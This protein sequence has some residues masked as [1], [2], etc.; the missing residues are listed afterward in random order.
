[1]PP[2][3]KKS[4][5][6]DGMRRDLAALYD[7]DDRHYHSMSHVEDL[8]RL[9]ERHADLIDNAAE[10]EAAIWF[11]DAILDTHRNDNEARSADLARDWLA[12][13]AGED[14]IGRIALMI[15]ATASHMLP[16]DV[17][18]DLRARIALFLDMDLSILGAEPERFDAYEAAVRKEYDWVPQAAWRE[19]R[20][21]VLARF[22][23]RPAIFVTT[24]FRDL[25]EARARA[26]LARSLARL[27]DPA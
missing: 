1:M 5:L 27:N 26:N 10:M 25:F 9:A 12:P 2:P 19:G 15:E 11:H 7:A 3:V 6:D 23:E 17:S 22:L 8:L 18:G 14:S 21:K 13:R 24:R 20:A 16:Q 4:L